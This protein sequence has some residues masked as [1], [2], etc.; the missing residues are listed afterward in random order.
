[1]LLGVNF[2]FMGESTPK[3]IYCVESVHHNDWS[4]GH[5]GD[6]GSACLLQNCFGYGSPM[7]LWFLRD[8]EWQSM[9]DLLHGTF[10]CQL[11]RHSNVLNRHSSFH[12]CVWA[13][14]VPW[15]W[16]ATTCTIHVAAEV[17]PMISGTR[18]TSSGS[19]AEAHCQ[20]VDQAPGPLTA[21]NEYRPILATISTFSHVQ[22]YQLKFIWHHLTMLS[23][24]YYCWNSPLVAKKYQF[25]NH[26]FLDG[27]N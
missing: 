12:L 26:L 10:N 22:H 5:G 17:G 1:M 14:E 27:S 15:W 9:T 13:L 21:M 2:R 25:I 6:A 7:T 18:V 20:L 3:K 24:C 4:R 11:N 23:D 16:K 19:L 8:A